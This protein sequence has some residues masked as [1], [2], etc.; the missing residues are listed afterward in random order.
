MA[1]KALDIPVITPSEPAHPWADPTELDLVVM[2]M[3]R[4]RYNEEMSVF[5]QVMIDII[6]SRLHL[7]DELPES[8]KLKTIRANYTALC[9][10]PTQAPQE[11]NLMFAK[12]AVLM[13][14]IWDYYHEP[15]KKVSK[16]DLISKDTESL[17]ELDSPQGVNQ[18]RAMS[19]LRALKARPKESLHTEDCKRIL[20]GVEGRMLDNKVIRRAMTVL[21]EIYSP[22]IIA[23]KYNGTYRVRIGC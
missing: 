11:S 15:A 2:G 17:N 3:D 12:A 14:Q 7:L 9:L 23:E 1:G 4:A 21:S 10:A 19:I 5:S 18:V 6:G 22:A 8:P 20:E 16:A 13:S